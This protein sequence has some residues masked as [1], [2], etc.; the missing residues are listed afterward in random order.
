EKDYSG[1]SIGIP[2]KFITNPSY[3]IEKELEGCEYVS[4]V[5]LIDNKMLIHKNNWLVILDKVHKKCSDKIRLYPVSCCSIEAIRNNPLMPL[6]KN[7]ITFDS[8]P[9]ANNSVERLNNRKE[10]LIFELAHEFS[11]LL[12]GYNRVSDLESNTVPAG[13]NIFISHSREDGKKYAQD[14]NTYL[15][16]NTSLDRFIDVFDIY[17]GDDFEATIN[18]NLRSAALLV[19]CTDSY[20][21]R[22]WCQHEVVYAK[23]KRR[24]I[25]LVDMLKDGEKRRF[26]Y[27]ANIKTM[28]LDYGDI[29]DKQKRNIIL[30]I[31]FEVLR[32]K[33]SELKLSY[34]CRIFS[35][36]NISIFPYPPELLTLMIERKEHSDLKTV[37]YPEPPLNK[38]EQDILKTSMLDV[39]FF[40]PTFL[41]LKNESLKG[42]ILSDLAIG[43]SVSEIA[44]KSLSKTNAQ[45]KIMVVELCRYLI[46]L[47]ANLVYGGSFAV[48]T[49]FNF[50][51]ILDE[52]ISSYSVLKREGII[53]NIYLE[54]YPLEE[55]KI[56][57]LGNVFEFEKLSTKEESLAGRLTALRERVNFD[58]SVR[59]S[60]GGKIEG[61][62]G[63]LPGVI[64]ESLIAIRMNK[65]LFILGAYGGAAELLAKCIVGEEIDL[66]EDLKDLTEVKEKG[67][68]CLNN[69]LSNEE[70]KKLLFSDNMIE[71]I[72][73]IIK[74][75]NKLH[76]DKK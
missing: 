48:K 15:T 6:N 52:F 19:L 40:T 1:E 21:S 50:L 23:S 46:T 36:E 10:Y 60:I 49:K 70:N 51:N 9:I 17:K 74:G 71:N 41:L 47:G 56:V 53:K 65:P 42:N 30:N 61:Y 3:N 7:F 58:S 38:R 63:K 76:H 72:A 5:T 75:L 25:L 16:S 13:I 32:V 73:L 45:L 18:T 11:R 44:E 4:I 35:I 27:M 8:L 69:G 14:F 68:S 24:P 20:S 33:Y 22:E 55:D 28:H 34:L 67:L 12:Y 59:I 54:D 31:L 2:V 62:S 57:E 66:Q 37:L 64:E 43:L 29:S 39:N 26:P